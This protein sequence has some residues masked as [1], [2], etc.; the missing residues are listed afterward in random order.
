LLDISLQAERVDEAQ[1]SGLSFEGPREVFGF[2]VEELAVV[3]THVR[4]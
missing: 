2:A 1:L 4:A 3:L